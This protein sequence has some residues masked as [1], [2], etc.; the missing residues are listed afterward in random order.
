MKTHKLFILLV[1]ITA[2]GCA[3][4]ADVDRA[5]K[6]I[7]QPIIN[8]D[9]EQGVDALI[10]LAEKGY[11]EAQGEL[12]SLYAKDPSPDAKAQAARWFTEVNQ[13][14]D[15]YMSRYVRWL[16]NYAQQD[17]ALYD[18]AV[19]LLQQQMRSDG[20]VGPELVRLLAAKQTLSNDTLRSI[21]NMISGPDAEED[22]IKVLAYA[23]DLGPFL[24]EFDAL[25]Q[26]NLQMKYECLLARLR[27]AK[28]HDSESLARI[29]SQA[30]AAYMQGD[31]DDDHLT[32]LLSQ[33]VTTE[34]GAVPSYPQ[35]ARLLVDGAL[36]GNDALFL[37]F[38]KLDEAYAT[39]KAD[40]LARLEQLHE[41]GNAE[42]SVILA[43]IHIEGKHLVARPAVGER[44]LQSV[45]AHEDAK[46]F[47]GRLYLSGRL[48]Y[49]KLQQGVDLL[50]DSGRQGNP[51]AYR[52]LMRVFSGMRGV[53]VN[54]VYA[55][56]FAGV[57]KLFG[58]TL[59]ERDQARLDALTLTSQERT[60]VD[61]NIKNEMASVDT[62]E[63]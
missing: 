33:L 11:V 29:V 47:L 40:I 4:L 3:N 7:D 5:K 12:A 15:R 59:A 56:T 16:A 34:G 36:T 35:F 41:A 27:Y 28:L 49:V 43:N 10:F 20:D 58:Y 38:A 39:G 42:A 32:R 23:D 60:Q 50:V 53:Q 18:E 19:L 54:G 13:H 62:T 22:G 17:D 31:I 24:A 2:A 48:G 46:F 63:S 44:Y 57:F 1:I 25:C 26:A 52:E 55:H 14:T 51:Q 9:Y 8:E 21:V 61:N 30:N 37:R 6:A 45:L